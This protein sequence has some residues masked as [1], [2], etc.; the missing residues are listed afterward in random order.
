MEGPLWIE[1]CSQEGLTRRHGGTTPYLWRSMP[2]EAY[3]T[4]PGLDT[5]DS[6]G[7]L[8]PHFFSFHIASIYFLNSLL[9]KLLTS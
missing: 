8:F 2:P 9:L 3:A 5:G 1:A 4:V 6:L 7:R